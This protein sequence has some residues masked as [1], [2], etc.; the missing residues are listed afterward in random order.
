MV[1]SA[2]LTFLDYVGV[3]FVALTDINYTVNVCAIEDARVDICFLVYVDVL[4][5]LSQRLPCVLV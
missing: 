5:W 2:E 4:S 3:R 1:A